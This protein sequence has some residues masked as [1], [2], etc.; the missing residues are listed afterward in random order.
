VGAPQWSTLAIAL[1]D[2]ADLPTALDAFVEGTRRDLQG[3]R[4]QTF[5][6]QGDIYTVQFRP[7]SPMP[8]PE[9]GGAY[10][11]IRVSVRTA[12][13]FACDAARDIWSRFIGALSRFVGRL[14]GSFDAARRQAMGSNGLFE[15]CGEAM[16][17]YVTRKLGNC[18]ALSKPIDD[19]E[20]V[21]SKYGLKNKWTTDGG[22]RRPRPASL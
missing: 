17:R 1:K 14:T 11:T 13:R 20:A 2:W 12:D 10:P 19:V 21:F 18:V 8:A 5:L 16:Q 6:F 7:A 22:R 9:L 3:F 4:A 15:S